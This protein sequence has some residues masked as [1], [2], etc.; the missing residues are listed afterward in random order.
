[1]EARPTGMAK[2][3]GHNEKKIQRKIPMR[4][5]SNQNHDSTM[6]EQD[7]LWEDKCR[8]ELEIR[9]EATMVFGPLGDRN[10]REIMVEFG[11]L[12]SIDGTH[13]EWSRLLDASCVAERIRQEMGLGDP[14]YSDL[15]ATKEM[16]M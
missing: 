13:E 6:T 3:D 14:G 12:S 7:N 8:R 1:M 10:V 4:P 15:P 2:L 5:E 11:L 9:D 16:Q